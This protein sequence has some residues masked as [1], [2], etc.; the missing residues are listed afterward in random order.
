MAILRGSSISTVQRR[1][2]T[3]GQGVPTTA[4][5]LRGPA[6]ST[7]QHQPT[8]T[9]GQ[10]VPTTAASLHGPAVSTI[11]HQPTTTTGQ[12][13]PTSVV[14]LHGP[15]I[16]TAQHHPTTTTGQGG[17]RTLASSQ[18]GRS[19]A[20]S[21]RR[22]KSTPSRGRGR[23]IPSANGNSFTLSSGPRVYS[24]T[25]LLPVDNLTGDDGYPI[26]DEGIDTPGFREDNQDIEREPLDARNEAAE[27]EDAE[28][29]GRFF[30]HELTLCL[31]DCYERLEDKFNNPCRLPYVLW[32]RVTIRN[33]LL[34]WIYIEFIFN[35]FLR[36]L[37]KWKQMVFVE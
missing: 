2:T 23:R 26:D 33:K 8:F 14:S 6:V 4:A 28:E 17:P 5:S 18:R 36:L 10:G 37:L 15:S 32:R 35:F 19:T 29:G 13:G 11:Q 3:T 31:L 22:G 30:N 20:P 1:S 9:T 27:N 12:G 34:R 24:R 25:G 21:I 16:A 7:I